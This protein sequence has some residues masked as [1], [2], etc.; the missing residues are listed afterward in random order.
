[1]KRATQVEETDWIIIRVILVAVKANNAVLSDWTITRTVKYLT[2]K[3]TE[4]TLHNAIDAIHAERKAC[5]G[6]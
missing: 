4:K 1:M 5:H 6:N 2:D 3:Y